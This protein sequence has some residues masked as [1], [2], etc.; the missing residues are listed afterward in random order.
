MIGTTISSCLLP[1]VL[2]KHSMFFVKY[3]EAA[4]EREELGLYAV[5]AFELCLLYTSQLTVR[6]AGLTLH[7]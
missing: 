5:D 3:L 4:R 2:G 6:C 1:N 7:S